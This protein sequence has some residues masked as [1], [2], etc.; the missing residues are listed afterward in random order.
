MLPTLLPFSQHQEHCKTD[1][2]SKTACITDGCF[3]IFYVTDSAAY[4][5]E[6]DI[7]MELVTQVL[8]V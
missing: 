6:Y 2:C 3:L 8:L 1:Y 5:M 7:S 4:A